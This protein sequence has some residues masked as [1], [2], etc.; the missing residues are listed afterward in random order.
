[1]CVPCPIGWVS[2]KVGAPN[3]SFCYECPRGTGYA[4][5]GAVQ[6]Q[7]CLGGTFLQYPP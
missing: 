5:L 2:S 1:V 7:T 6:C 4:A 3:S